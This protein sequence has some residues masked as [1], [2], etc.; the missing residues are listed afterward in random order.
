MAS[1]SNRDAMYLASVDA[2]AAAVQ[3]GGAVAL[4]SAEAVRQQ[5][6]GHLRG[7]VAQC[8]DRGIADA[9]T[10]EGRYALVAFIDD[11]ILKSD[12]AGRADWQRTPLQLQFYREFTAGENFFRRMGGLIQR[13]EPVA[14][15]EVY[16]LCLALGFAGALPAAG[17]GAGP[18]AQSGAHSYLEAAR[19]V[20][21]RGTQ[22]T[23]LAPN[24][25][26]P[27]L[28]RARRRAVPI[29]LVVVLTCAGLCLLGLLGL[30][31]SLGHVIDATRG[32]LA[33]A[34]PAA[35]PLGER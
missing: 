35:A 34:R 29:A 2:L 3:L 8:R 17:S 24:A 7:F 12:W 10:A 13:G 6:V 33:A 26:P 23:S 9:E 25:I 16:Y 15:L 11:R 1:T 30:Q 5:M 31:L 20:L 21:L 32:D 14:A 18:A 19:G 28:H 27:E 4:G 22:P